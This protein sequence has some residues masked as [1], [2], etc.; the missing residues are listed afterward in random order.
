MTEQ[1]PGSSLRG[2][3][4]PASE[5]S[6]DR[7]S[8]LPSAPDALH[9]D[10]D[11]DADLHDISTILL[12]AKAISGK[13]LTSAGRMSVSEEAK[14]HA[15][16]DQ[17]K[18]AREQANL[19][20]WNTQ[21]TTVGG[22]Q[23]TNEQAQRARQNIIDNDDAYADWAVRKGLISEDQKDDFKAGVRRKKEL[24]DKRGRGTLTT[25]EAAEEARFDQSGVGKAID[26]ATARD[27]QHQGVAPSSESSSPRSDAAMRGTLSVLDR[28]ALFQSAPPVGTAFQTASADTPERKA[29]APVAPTIKSTGLDL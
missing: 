11:P 9:L 3:L 1:E 6:A 2:S 21:M 8:D 15:L 20:R 24:E 13:A 4:A 28:P 18:Q 12:G 22:V 10:E 19:A 16:R 27:Y 29:P 14:H 17:Q 7:R 5:P 26:A 25:A 23:M